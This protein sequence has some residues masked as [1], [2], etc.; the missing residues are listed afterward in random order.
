MNFN[1]NHKIFIAGANG[2]VGSSILRLL[3]KMNLRTFIILIEKS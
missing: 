3:E 1:H 2:M